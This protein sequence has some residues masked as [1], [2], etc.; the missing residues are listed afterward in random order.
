MM[1]MDFFWQISRE[2]GV[3]SLMLLAL[4]ECRGQSSDPIAVTSK[5]EINVNGTFYVSPA[6]N[7]A[8]PGT[9]EQP[10]AT[11]RRASEAA[12]PG[13][14]VFLRRGAYAET[15]TPDQSGLPNAPITFSRYAD[16]KVALVSGRL[17][18]GW[19]P[20]GNGVYVA[21]CP[22]ALEMGLNQV[23][24]N[25][26][27]MI[28]ART[29][30]VKDQNELVHTFGL[31]RTFV[32]VT[33][34]NNVR[35]MEKRADLKTEETVTYVGRHAAAWGSQ[36]ATGTF[37]D[38]GRMHILTRTS[39]GHASWWKG[40]GEG[41][42]VGARNYLDHEREWYLDRK[43]KK[44][45][46]IPPQGTDPNTMKVYV[47]DRE[48]AIDLKDRKNIVVDGVSTLMGAVRMENSG[49]CTIRNSAL[50]YGGHH[51]FFENP[52][53]YEG[54]ISS[55]SGVFMTGSKNLIEHCKI[56]WN[57][58]ASIVI[59]G[60]DNRVLNSRLH[61]SGLLGSYYSGIYIFQPAKLQGGGHEIARNTIYNCGRGAIHISSIGGWGNPGKYAKPMNIHHNDISGAMMVCD[62]GGAIYQF[63]TD[64]AGSEIHHNW[65]FGTKGLMIYFDNHSFGW[66]VHHNV[67]QGD[68]N[69][70]AP[71]GKIHIYNN[72]MLLTR[73]Y[74]TK[75]FS[76]SKSFISNNIDPHFQGGTTCNGVRP[77]Y[78]VFAADGAGGLKY[79]VKEVREAGISKGKPRVVSVTGD[80]LPQ[81]SPKYFGAY[82]YGSTSSEA[83]KPWVAG[84]DWGGAVP[85]IPKRK[86]APF[87]VQASSFSKSEGMFNNA[88]F[89]STTGTKA[90]AHYDNIDFS[91]GY[92]HVIFNVMMAEKMGDAVIELR[93]DGREGECIARSTVK[94]NPA[95][96]HQFS[97]LLAKLKT[98]TGRHDVYMV[99]QA[100]KK[101]NVAEFTFTGAE[102]TPLYR[103]SPQELISEDGSKKIETTTYA[104]GSRVLL[105][106]DHAFKHPGIWMT[107]SYDL[108][109]C[110]PGNWVFFPRVDFGPDCKYLMINVGDRNDRNPRVEL[111]SGAPDGQ[112]LGTLDIQRGNKDK[113]Q[114]QRME[115]KDASG[116]HDLFVVF[117]KKFDGGLNYILFP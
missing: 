97:F 78:V 19:K 74:S 79:R 45:Y 73:Y 13:N 107:G 116:L 111:R 61:D 37:D 114:E 12:Q 10:F 86:D 2:A 56:A 84:C 22:V 48:F 76:A 88:L 89:V 26:E 39:K 62:D 85:E 71:S 31:H 98:V 115:L 28:E 21:D 23:I 87:S 6:G 72:T 29:P 41:Y 81:F 68:V 103:V 59:G 108:K 50:L 30:N 46:F 5:P 92:S 63:C 80:T 77:P 1:N 36:T 60:E 24:C 66:N 35:T 25:G 17:I 27:L 106:V 69:L 90:W 3:A 40:K 105:M 16:E 38:N 4:V 82:E 75:Y 110:A 95:E 93:L 91:S 99:V 9:K 64:G 67:I 113:W 43:N 53:T 102:R 52:Y 7:D 83:Q 65:V 57:S 51:S 8:S 109:N 49:N 42:V 55:R 34:E 58:A 54:D 100:E 70:N 94:Y 101:L 32:G 15:L 20:I 18:A 104:E 33:G 96:S 112:L 44:L 47:K 117:P 11:I 14:T